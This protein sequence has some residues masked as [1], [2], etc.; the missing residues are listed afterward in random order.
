MCLLLEALAHQRALAGTGRAHDEKIVALARDAQTKIDSVARA[1]VLSLR[2]AVVAN[3]YG[4][5]SPW[6][7]GNAACY[8]VSGL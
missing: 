2:S 8:V 1:P 5:H 7:S 3:L 6:I 4:L